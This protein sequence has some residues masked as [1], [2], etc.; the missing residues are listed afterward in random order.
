MLTCEALSSPPVLNYTWIRGNKS[1]VEEQ[2]KQSFNDST[3]TLDGEQSDVLAY[4][5]IAINA[6]GSSKPCSLHTNQLNGELL[7]QTAHTADNTLTQS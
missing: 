6:I 5:C 7:D 1:V 3:L 4:T 2:E